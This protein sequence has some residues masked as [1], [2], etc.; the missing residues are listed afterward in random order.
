VNNLRSYLEEI[1][2]A[3]GLE[4]RSYDRSDSLRWPRDTLYPLKLAL[5]S[6]TGGDRSIG[7]VRQRTKTTEYATL[8]IIWIWISREQRFYMY[9]KSEELYFTCVCQI[10]G[11]DSS[12]STVARQWAGWAGNKD[13][14]PGRGKK[15]ISSP[16]SQDWLWSP[17][18]TLSNVYRGSF[19]RTEA[20][21]TES[22]SP[23]SKVV[24]NVW[25]YTSTAP[26]IFMM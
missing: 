25:S 13:F 8:K 3:P 21:G 7:I 5:A 17:T 20:N 6:L 24:M 2:A 19:N 11:W 15:F 18:S 14:L 10:H 9:I 1:V 12:F 16:Q 23:S 22:S 26:Y 4:N